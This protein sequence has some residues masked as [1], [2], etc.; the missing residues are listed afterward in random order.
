M[1]ALL[2][3]IL[4]L[5][6]ALGAP[7]QAERIKDLGQFD[8]LRANQLTGYGVVVGL[9]G[10]GDDSLDYSTLGVKGAV[11]RFGLS[12]PAGSTRRSRT[13]RRF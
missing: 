6:L 13:P 11:S 12:L 8:G 9:S 3:I 7:A 1:R 10:T 5:G 4:P 2:R